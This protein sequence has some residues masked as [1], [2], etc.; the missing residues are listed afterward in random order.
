MKQMQINKCQICF[1]CDFFSRSLFIG[2]FINQI[3]I[4]LLYVCLYCFLIPSISSSFSLLH[5]QQQQQ[6]PYHIKTEE[7]E[8]GG[9]RNLRK[10]RRTAQNDIDPYLP[11]DAAVSFLY[12]CLCLC[13]FISFA[14]YET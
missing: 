6:H 10:H 1:F 2:V 14:W 9:K 5:H 12:V 11:Y 8:G 3:L 7:E 4:F 13:F